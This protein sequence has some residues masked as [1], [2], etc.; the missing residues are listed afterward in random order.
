MT[1]PP[2]ASLRFAAFGSLLVVTIAPTAESIA[3]ESPP[4]T[5]APPQTQTPW[6]AVYERFAPHGELPDRL[7]GRLLLAELSCTACHQTSDPGLIPKAGPNLIHA[8]SRLRMDWVAAF[9]RSPSVAKPGTTMPDLLHA[10]DD[11]TREETVQGLVAYLHSLRGDFPPVRGSGLVPVPHRFWDA[12]DFDRGRLTYH[13]VGCVACHAPDPDE[14]PPSLGDAALDALLDELDPEEL[15]ELGLASAARPVAPVPLPD[16]GSK[17]DAKSL[18][19]FLY[20]PESVRPAGRMPNLKLQPMEAADIAAYLRYRDSAE[21]PISPG[22]TAP[23]APTPDTTP[24]PTDGLDS[25][26]GPDSTDVGDSTDAPD[27]TDGPDSIDVVAS[28]ARGQSAARTGPESWQDPARIA[29]GRRDFFRLGCAQCHVAGDLPAEPG[30]IAEARPLRDLDPVSLSAPGSCASRP[31]ADRPDYSLSP[32][33]REAISLA[34]TGESPESDERG[35]ATAT[36]RMMQLNC[37]A[38]HSRDGR[39]G[40]GRDQQPHFAT[41]GDVD[42]GDEGRLPPPLTGVGRK[43]KP[44]WLNKVFAGKGDIRPHM[45]ARMPLY[46][47]DQIEGLA[48]RLAEEDR[49]APGKSASTRSGRRAPPEVSPDALA[50]AG[51]RLMDAGCVQCHPLRGYALPGV[52]G[53]DLGGI[54]DRVHPQWFHDFVADPGGWRPRTRMPT[55]FPDGQSQDASILDGDTEQQLAALWHYLKDSDR[56]PLPAKIEQARSADYE[57]TPQERPIVLRTFMTTA[58]THAIAV[59]FPAGVHFAFDA[60]QGRL[61]TAWRD[62]FLDAQGTWFSRFAPPAEPLG[63]DPVGIDV[64]SPRPSLALPSSWAAGVPPD[65]T[66]T[67]ASPVESSSGPFRF[68]GYRLDESGTPT[69]LYLGAGVTVEDR[70]EPAAA[71]APPGLSRRL[72]LR[73]AADAPDAE[74]IAIRLA[75]AADIR[76]GEADPAADARD[77]WQASLPETGLRLRLRPSEALRPLTRVTAEGAEW[78]VVAELGEET[79]TVEVTYQW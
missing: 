55:F 44:S 37:Y 32:E 13:R 17:Y 29:R 12:G 72:T 25:T 54:A 9:L 2:A 36:S 66:A 43:L 67:A 63:D 52:V 21:Q 19:H 50:D 6:V 1:G 10:M 16:L 68:G 4:Q 73:R 60:R 39:G 33:Q 69:F 35:S 15:E 30:E 5:Q 23:E 65:P 20:R 8:G 64:T 46:P 76:A 53:V 71:D 56:Y 74:P 75:S 59:G 22:E 48:Q 26:D 14:Q 24:V 47:A 62:R 41:R 79:Q 57:L 70:I 49:E 3:A 61:A 45:L 77:D 58:G 7:A 27:S 11:A 18:T 38:C 28:V 34:L 78:W 51:R 40:V 42:L 31:A